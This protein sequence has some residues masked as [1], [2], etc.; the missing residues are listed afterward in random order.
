MRQAANMNRRHEEDEMSHTSSTSSMDHDS[1]HNTMSAQSMMMTFFSASNTPIYSMAFMPNTVA[2]Y[3]GVCLFLIILGFVFRCLLAIRCN[4][5]PILAWATHRRD[6]SILRQ[7]SQDK[8]A[9]VAYRHS[10]RRPWRINEA[11]LRAVLDTT[12]A[13]ASYLL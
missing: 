4:F 10:D 2:Q 12:L 5:L 11:L 1:D 3:F 6:T 8:N 9:A 13:A 7:S